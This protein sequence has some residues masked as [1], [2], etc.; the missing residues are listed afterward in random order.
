MFASK[1]VVRTASVPQPSRVVEER[2]F[3]N[4]DQLPVMFDHF[5]DCVLN[6]KQPMLPMEEGLRDLEVIEAL[7]ESARTGKAVKPSYAAV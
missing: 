5:S 2:L 1:D 3:A 7:Y 6:D 4:V